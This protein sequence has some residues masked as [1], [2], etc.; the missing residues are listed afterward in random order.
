VLPMVLLQFA[1]K[2]IQQNKEALQLQR[3]LGWF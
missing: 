3:F 2:S 1:Q